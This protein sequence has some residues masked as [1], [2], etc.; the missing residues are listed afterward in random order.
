[1]V[2]NKEGC[3]CHYC[4]LLT[5]QYLEHHQLLVLCSKHQSLTLLNF[6]TE[7]LQ[8]SK[9]WYQVLFYNHWNWDLDYV[10]LTSTWLHISYKV[11]L[12]TLPLNGEAG[13]VP[14]GRGQ[15]CC[16]RSEIDIKFAS[17]KEW[18]PCSC[19][20]AEDNS[21]AVSG[22]LSSI[23]SLLTSIPTICAQLLGS[24]KFSHVITRVRMQLFHFWEL[25]PPR[26]SVRAPF[27]HNRSNQQNKGD[28]ISPP[29]PNHPSPSKS[30]P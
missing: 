4:H 5:P 20:P 26:Y 27:C 30:L 2:K 23:T 9:T 15:I 6:L 22:A 10:G 29:G 1:M 3:W 11:F 7:K 13:A 28:H 17:C 16:W 8:E 12:R 19:I 25:P 18:K 14:P 21:W 24:L